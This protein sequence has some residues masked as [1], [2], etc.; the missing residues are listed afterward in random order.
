MGR[1]ETQVAIVGAGIA[2]LALAFDL[3]KKG[4]DLVVLEASDRAGG[5]IRSEQRD[6]YLIEWGPNGF[7]DS[8][9]STLELVSALGLEGRLAPAARVAAERFLVRDGRLRALPQ[10][11]PAFLTSDVLSL[12]GRPRCLPRFARCGRASG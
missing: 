2:G 9:P 3:R 6:G 1:T 7:L 8:E 4:V 11:P 12:R 10:S 5:N